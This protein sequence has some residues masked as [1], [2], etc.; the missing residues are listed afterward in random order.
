MAEQSCMG[1]LIEYDADK[2]IEEIGAENHR[3]RRAAR[4]ENWMEVWKL[5]EK[6]SSMIGLSLPSSLSSDLGCQVTTLKRRINVIASDVTEGD[7]ILTACGP[8]LNDHE[9]KDFGKFV[10]GPILHSRGWSTV[11]NM[12]KLKTAE[13]SSRFHSFF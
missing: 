6:T 12:E 3:L 7:E 11:P 13:V 10:R 2:R 4:C 9:I 1:S 8:L 5:L